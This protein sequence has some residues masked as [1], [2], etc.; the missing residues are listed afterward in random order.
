MTWA[1]K[2]ISKT[3]IL[4]YFWY[5]FLYRL[6]GIVQNAWNLELVGLNDGDI[7]SFLP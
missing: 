4:W 6:F 5:T 3:R 2:N 7:Q 1:L